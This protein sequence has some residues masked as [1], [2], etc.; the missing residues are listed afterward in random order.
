[1]T[2][3]PKPGKLLN[4]R[5]MHTAARL[6]Y[7]DGLSQVEV[8]RRMEVSTA[9]IS[10]LLGL[11]RDEGIVRIQVLDLDEADG[12]ADKL[13]AALGL[14]FVRVTESDKAAALSTQVGALLSEAGLAPGAVVAIGWG[15]TVQSVISAGLPRIPE[16]VVV[17]TTGGM[18]ETA[19]HFQINE[20]VRM[21]AEQMGGEARLLYAPSMVSPELLSVLSRDPATARLTELWARVDAAIVGIGAYLRD[22]T[23]TDMGFGADQAAR[24]AGDVVR[25]YFD[26]DGAE[27]RWPG[28]ENQMS[29]GRAQLE[30]IPLAIGVAMGRDKARSIIGAARS[31]MINALVTD[32][33]AASEMLDLLERGESA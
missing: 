32:T 27:I 24:V 18:Q 2:K 3:G 15:R 8:A 6:H 19:S 13:A 5:M 1:M 30:R 31:G 16:V 21:A 26:R 25:H 7:L 23:T 9:T 10:R 33:R 4:R 11:A 28:Q 12:Q 22:G 20:F 29:I 14:T 17:P